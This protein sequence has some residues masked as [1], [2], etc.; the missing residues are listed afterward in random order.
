MKSIAK[1]RCD[2]SVMTREQD[3]GSAGRVFQL[4]RLCGPAKVTAHWFVPSCLPRP[5]VPGPTGA[6]DPHHFSDLF[7]SLSTAPLDRG[8]ARQDLHPV[9]RWTRPHREGEARGGSAP[10]ALFVLRIGPSLRP[11]LPPRPGKTTCVRFSLDSPVGCA[12]AATPPF[13]RGC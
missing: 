9:I 10:S 4:P 5:S 12:P 1:T 11:M 8:V 3:F 6:N 2:R 7:D 13:P